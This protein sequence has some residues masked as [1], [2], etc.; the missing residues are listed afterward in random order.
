[1][2]EMF[3]PEVIARYKAEIESMSAELEIVNAQGL[4]RKE[5]LSAKNSEVATFREILNEMVAEARKLQE[6]QDAERKRA[7]ELQNTIEER[8]RAMQR[9]ALEEAAYLERQ[10]KKQKFDEI[11]ENAPWRAGAKPHQLT[12][13]VDMASAKRAILG[14]KTGLGKTLTAT[15]TLDMIEADKILIFTPK[16]VINNFKSEVERW[17]PHR[18]VVTLDGRGKSAR[19]DLFSMLPFLD[20]FVLIINYAAW[21]KDPELLKHLIACQFEAVIIDEAHNMK[22]AATSIAQG[23]RQVVYAENQCNICGEDVVPVKSNRM[24]GGTVNQCETCFAVSEKTGQFCSVKYVYPLTATGILNSPEDLFTL[25]NLVDRI[26]Y[27]TAQR[28]LEDFCERKSS[29]VDGKER[30]YW[31]FKPGGE[32]LLLAKLGSSYIARDRHDA[33]VVMP[34]QQV[35]EHWFDI[36]TRVYSKQVDV[37]RNLQKLGLVLMSKEHIMEVS[38]NSPLAWY[39]RMRQALV[40]PK[41]IKVKDPETGEILYEADADESVVIDNAMDLIVQ[42]V[43]EGDRVYVPSMFKEVLKEFE[44]RLNIEG[45]SCVRYDGDISDNK[46]EEVKRDFDVKYC[47]TYPRSAEKPD[48]YKW[49]VILGHYEK[50]GTGINLQACTQTVVPDLNWN[51]GKMDQM[52]GRTNRMDSL[53]DSVVHMVFIDAFISKWMKDIVDSK[54]N[55]IDG[56]EGEHQK[57]MRAAMEEFMSGDMF[58]P[59]NN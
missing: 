40:W 58:A 37:I 16:D 8:Q 41:G 45:I 12:G 20:K 1:M 11:T 9:M 43:K 26:A 3:D 25:L 2:N 19:D 46:A 56:F 22:N 18:K 14:D 39:T 15:M 55:V 34:E 36:D 42:A 10:K 51:P 54:R 21:R 52:F 35:R 48:G 50:S 28:F 24:G 23:I 31:G 17:A 33:G 4:A 29:W 27:P 5:E 38:G 47:K 30:M 32:K 44:R 53:K 57:S 59:T 49:Q 6:K 13:A 7:R